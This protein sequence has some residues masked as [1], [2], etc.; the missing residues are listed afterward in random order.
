MELIASLT[1][2]E[3]EKELMEK[4]K[5]LLKKDLDIAAEKIEKEKIIS[6]NLRSDLLRTKGLFTS[7]GIFEYILSM[8]WREYHSS[9]DKQ[10]RFNASSA[11]SIISKQLEHGTRPSGKYS[12]DLYDFAV[13]CGCHDLTS[14]YSILSFDIHGYQ[15][16]GRAVLIY[17]EEIGPSYSC[18]LREVCDS[19]QIKHE[20]A[21]TL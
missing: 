11:A 20:N 3:K 17:A 9:K 16:T 2:K 12:G 19:L 7:R 13:K 4:E 8:S 1:K 6:A 14:L 21:T 18:F 5:E 15:W 10:P